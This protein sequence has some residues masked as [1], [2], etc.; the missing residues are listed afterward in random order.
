MSSR[1]RLVWAA[2]AAAG[3][4][5]LIVIIFNVGQ[6]R[7]P[8]HASR[9]FEIEMRTS[10]GTSAQLFWA[11]DLRFVEERS[12]RIPLQP[13]PEG[14]QRL[15]FPLPPNGIR[16]LRFDPTDAP[17]D[18]LIGRMR[19]FDSNHQLLATFDPQTFRPANQIASMTQQEAGTKITTT[20]G[21]TDPF[22]FLSFARLDRFSLCDTLWLV[23][24]PALL[25]VSIIAIALVAASVVI[26]GVAAFRTE[27]SAI[28]PDSRGTSWRLSALWITVLFLLVFSAKLLLMRENPVT[29]PFWDQWDGEAAVLFVPYQQESLAWRTMFDFHNE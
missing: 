14:F 8:S 20:P 24:P 12:V 2:I 11:A 22:L 3:L 18:V 5:V 4:V 7:R 13:G 16:W 9:T 6:R 28:P 27:Q 23:T 25:V 15:R 17:A 10:A 19:L 21:A 1:H 26:I 29:V